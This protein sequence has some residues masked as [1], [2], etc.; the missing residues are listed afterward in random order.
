MDRHAQFFFAEGRYWVKDLTGRNSITVDGLPVQAQASLETF[1]TLRL[2]PQGPAFRFLGGG[3]FAELE[4]D[5]PQEAVDS[6][7]EER[8]KPSRSSQAGRGKGSGPRMKKFWGR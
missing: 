4:E 5:A 1:G 3:R 7:G 6:P 8:E 2:S